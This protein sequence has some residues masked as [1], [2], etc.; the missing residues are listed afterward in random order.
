MAVVVGTGSKAYVLRYTR[1]EIAV[2]DTSKG[3][4]AA[5]PIG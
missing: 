5:V 4:D 2:I 1:N 3:G